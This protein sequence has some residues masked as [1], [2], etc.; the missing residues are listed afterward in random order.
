MKFLS[1]CSG[2]D[3]ASV[4]S[5]PLGW[6]CVGFSEIE[7][8]PCAVLANRYPSV[9]NFGD[10]TKY[11]EWPEQLFIDADAIVGGPP[12]QAF[13]MAGKREGLDDARG[14]LTLIYA[15]LIDHADRIRAAHGKPPVW[16]LYEN[17]PGLLSDRTN[18]FGCLLGK[19]AGE[20]DALLP[21]GGKWT[22]AGF[23]SGP[24]RSIAWRILDAQYFGV[25]QRRRR[26]FV[27]AGSGNFDPEKVLFESEGVRRD[28]APGREAGKGVA[29]ITPFGVGENSELAHCL[30]SQAS[31]ADKHESTTYVTYRWQNNDAGIVPD[32]VAATIKAKG[33][34][35]D[36]RSVG[37]IVCAAHV[38]ANAETRTD[39]AAPTLTCNHEAPIVAH[40]P[41][42][43]KVR[44]GC[45]GGGKG[46][47]GQEDAAFT[48]ATGIDQHLFHQMAVRR[49]SPVECER[50]QGFPDSW[51]MIPWKN[52]P[53]AECPD[54]PRY[55]ALGNSWA[56]P[57]A[58][59]IFSRI[60]N[61]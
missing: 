52:K 8:F 61:A 11:A 14:N 38:Q 3:A 51:T 16:C 36:E 6:E 49:L 39:G 35:T 10:M 27:V 25:A 1:L 58:R 30:R 60:H 59:W 57:C 54:G 29:G 21:T 5:A 41:T 56:V 2:I 24:S 45:E 42:C 50:L 9:T 32:D 47:L 48:L 37:A 13:S 44:C 15:N 20:D 28:F 55:K 19:L 43:F 4:A 53:A 31:K 46:Y 12:C 40:P 17:V 33:T 7:P 18:A 34:T 26:V 22:N 23:V